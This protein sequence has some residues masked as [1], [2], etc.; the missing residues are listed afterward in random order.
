MPA[1]GQRCPGR[2]AG[3]CSTS[4]WRCA[5]R[6]GR[7]AVLVAERSTSRLPSTRQPDRG[8]PPDHD[9][10]RAHRRHLHRDGL[11]AGRGPEVETEQF[12]FDALNFPPTIPR[13]ANR[14]PSTSPQRAPGSCAHPHLPG[15]GAHP[16]G[17]R[18]AGV[19]RLDRAH[20]PHRRTRR[21]PHP[22]F[23][24]VEGLAVDRGRPWPSEAARWTPSPARSSGPEG[25]PGS[26]RTSSRSP[27][28]PRR[29]TSG[30][31][32]RRAGR[33]GRVGRLRHGES[34][35]CAPPEST[36]TCIRLR[37]RHGPGAHPAVPQRDT[38][39]A[40]HGRGRRPVLAAAFGV[41]V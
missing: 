19:H 4:A 38:R 31:R 11:G 41:G 14:T 24:Q 25:R 27:S 18:A 2:R 13:A 21:D 32:T 40:R 29:S 3:D 36:P 37:L 28:R 10:G 20:L 34:E 5:C 22:V 1:T 35:R 23:H 33:L 39:H 17:P 12:N 7:A 6:A 16:A 8:L 15:A 26:V 30:S 9:P